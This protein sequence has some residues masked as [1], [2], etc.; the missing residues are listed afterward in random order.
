MG[1]RELLED[2]CTD[3]IPE[4]EGRGS[5]GMRTEDCAELAGRGSTGMRTEDGAELAGRGST[6]MGTEDWEEDS[7]LCM[8]SSPRNCPG[9]MYAVNRPPRN[10]S[11]ALAD[12]RTTR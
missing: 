6:G 10:S 7:P 11:S 5:T 12:A 1:R 8:D 9:V 2:A 4:L 3:E